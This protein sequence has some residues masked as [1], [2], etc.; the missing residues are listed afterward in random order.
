MMRPAPTHSLP[1][2]DPLVVDADQLVHALGA[3]VAAQQS[4]AIGVGG[5]RDQ[6][7]VHRAS[8][9]TEGAQPA[10]QRGLTPRIEPALVGKRIDDELGRCGWVDPQV[11]WEPREY[12]EGLEHCVT[13]ERGPV[14]EDGRP[15]DG[16]RFVRL[17]ECRDGD[18]RVDRP[19]LVSAGRCHGARRHRDR[20]WYVRSPREAGGGPG[21]SR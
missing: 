1:W 18:A 15:A 11:A 7:I 2:S 4:S 19:R 12:G 6:G 8:G 16:M 13:G 5:G 20:R 21:P 17:V 10:K 9:Q 3:G 14:F